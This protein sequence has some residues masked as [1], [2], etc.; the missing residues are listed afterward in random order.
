MMLL[1][2]SFK[3]CYGGCQVNVN[4]N[5]GSRM[6]IF[7]IKTFYQCT[8]AP[9]SLQQHRHRSLR[10]K[11]AERGRNLTPHVILSYLRPALFLHYFHSQ[12]KPRPFTYISPQSLEQDMSHLRVQVLK[13]DIISSLAIR[14]IAFHVIITPWLHPGV[15]FESVGRLAIRLRYQSLLTIGSCRLSLA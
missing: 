1:K 14:T 4:L 2:P 7:A 12:V 15:C 3:R 6:R 8:P 5:V 13:N 9:P 10:S 11:S